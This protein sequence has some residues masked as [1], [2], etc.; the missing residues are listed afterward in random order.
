MWVTVLP[1]LLLI[2]IMPLVWMFSFRDNE[3]YYFV[4]LI[5]SW[6][7]G[8][9]LSLMGRTGSRRVNAISDHLI[10]RHHRHGFSKTRVSSASML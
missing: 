6:I 4:H 3:S 7:M 8:V 10:R 9:L 5:T 1:E 2:F